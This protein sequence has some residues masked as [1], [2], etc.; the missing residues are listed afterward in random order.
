M[1][2]RIY[3]LAKDLGIDNKELLDICE[4][5]GIKGKGSALASLD[6]GEIAKIKQH[7]IL[8]I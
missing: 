2:V 8:T 1:S 6:D 7:I 5:A 4:K 3:A